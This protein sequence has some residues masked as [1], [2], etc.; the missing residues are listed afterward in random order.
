MTV[1]EERKFKAS[2]DTVFLAQRLESLT[3]GESITYKA[4]GEVIGKTVSGATPALASARRI[5]LREHKRVFE[6]Q[7]GVGLKRLDDVGITGTGD[8]TRKRIRAEA[9]RGLKRLLAVN[10]FSAMPREM[11]MKHTATTALLGIVKGFTTDK[12]L[13]K[14]EAKAGEVDRKLTRYQTLEAFKKKG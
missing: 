13:A 10:D 12:A 8:K 9:R 14:V 1:T 11:Q 2:A 5:L 7:I 6:T 3:V 4:L